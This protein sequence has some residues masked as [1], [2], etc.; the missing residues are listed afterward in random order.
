MAVESPPPAGRIPRA[1]HR[2]ARALAEAGGLVVLLMMLVSVADV[3]LRYV[4]NAP[5]A[6]GY[7]IVQFAMVLV[8]YSGIAWCGVAGG[9]VSIDFLGTLLDRPGA[10]WINVLV[11]LAGGLLFLVVAWETAGTA[12]GA[13]RD[14]ASSNMLRIPY[15]PFH[16][17]VAVGAALFA[18]VLLLGAW[19][20]R[21]PA[22][23]TR[24]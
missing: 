14:A 2:L 19:Q 1:L 12:I 23:T 4:F 6:S 5:L 13:W 10:R 20:A 8:V 3:V 7:E 9:H 17:A 15:W 21:R 18:A 22:D 11:R 24:A 16:G